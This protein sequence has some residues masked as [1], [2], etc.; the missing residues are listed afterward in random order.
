MDILGKIMTVFLHGHNSKILDLFQNFLFFKINLLQISHIKF[1]KILL[2]PLYI[3]PVPYKILMRR[4][5][6][7]ELQ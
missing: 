1:S 3:F 4:P 7:G 5:E 6:T 2:E